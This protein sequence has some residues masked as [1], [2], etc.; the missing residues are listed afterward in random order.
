VSRKQIDINVDMGESFGM[1]KLGSDSEIM[2]FCTSANVACG[3]HAGDPHVMRQTVELARQKGVAVGVHFGLPDLI[4]F[5]RRIMAITPQQLKD[6]VTY[7]IGALKGF[8]DAAGVKLQHA[9]P[10]GALYLMLRQD[11][12]LAKA[13]AEAIRDVDD[14]MILFSWKNSAIYDV[15]KNM[16]MRVVNEFYADRACE[17]DEKIVFQF[18]LKNI[19]GSIGKA[20]ERTMRFVKE[21]KVVAFTGK[22]IEIEADTICVHGDSPI[23]LE[24]AS[25]LHEALEKANIEIRPVGTFSA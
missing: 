13:V 6:Y 18:D 14:R 10:H 19:G 15:A 7:Q 3:F 22:T 2:K 1:Y 23:A 12:K 21:G 9:K 24:L 8:T 17:E 11:E 4:G 16:G 5:G 20:V 25:A